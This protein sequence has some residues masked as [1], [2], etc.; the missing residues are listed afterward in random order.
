MHKTATPR[1]IAHDLL[2]T[3]QEESRKYFQLLKD[4]AYE[5]RGDGTGA[6]ALGKMYRYVKRKSG[7]AFAFLTGSNSLAAQALL[8]DS[9]NQQLNFQ[10]IKQNIQAAWNAVAAAPK[11]TTITH[12][13]RDFVIS[14]EYISP[15]VEAA[16][17]ERIEM[18]WDQANRIIDG[19]FIG[20]QL[21]EVQS[22]VSAFENA[23]IGKQELKDN[24]LLQRG[25]IMHADWQT[26]VVCQSKLNGL[27][28]SFASTAPTTSQNCPV[29]VFREATMQV[30]P[31]RATP[32]IKNEPVLVH[33]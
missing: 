27:R 20:P 17:Q 12:L 25:L 8:T 4:I 3:S 11:A 2:Q 19:T 6:T 1:D 21:P 16:L 28:N 33:A 15:E 5:R 14:A 10:L 29:L 32:R 24:L 18:D 26:P 23:E 9:F 22:L 7:A 30:S 31:E 13:Q